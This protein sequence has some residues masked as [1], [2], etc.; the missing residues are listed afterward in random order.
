MASAK[1]KG[2]DAASTTGP[3]TTASASH[4]NSISEV[5]GANALLTEIGTVPDPFETLA[6]NL[7]HDLWCYA[8]GAA[9]PN[10]YEPWDWDTMSSN[11]RQ[12]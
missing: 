8:E 12:G 2:R 11:S 10:L 6:A 3:K 9:E 1:K 7:N 5:Q 4:N